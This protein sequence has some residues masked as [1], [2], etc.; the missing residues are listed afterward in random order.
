MLVYSGLKTNFMTAVEED[1]IAEEIENNIYNLMHK[2]TRES[3]FRSWENSLEY[4]YKV[5]NDDSIPGNSGVA[6]E[7]NIPLTSKRID[8]IITGYNDD[9]TAIPMK[10]SSQLI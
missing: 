3:E 9:N 6:I 10:Y 7:Y 1:S 8:F 5:L 4:M 2:T